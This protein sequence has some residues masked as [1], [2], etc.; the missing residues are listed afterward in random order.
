MRCLTS[1]ELYWRNRDVLAIFLR[2]IRRRQE[3]GCDS[4]V[5]RAVRGW[6]ATCRTDFTKLGGHGF[7]FF[8]LRFAASHVHCD[9][10]CTFEAGWSEPEGMRRAKRMFQ[11]N[12]LG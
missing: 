2:E 7:P 9:E 6:K 4:H 8:V 3:R 5:R 12:G 11:G 10:G 1:P